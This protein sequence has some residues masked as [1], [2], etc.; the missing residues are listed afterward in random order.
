MRM[1]ETTYKVDCRHC[2]GTGLGQ[3]RHEGSKCGDCKG[4]GYFEK[5]LSEHDCEFDADVDC[6]ICPRCK[7]HTGFCSI[8]N[9]SECCG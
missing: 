8:C 2:L 6:D 9:S 5:P 3:V 7:E 4:R 1:K